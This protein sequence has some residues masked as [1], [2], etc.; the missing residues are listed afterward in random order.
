MITDFLEHMRI[1]VGFQV[2]NKYLRGVFVLKTKL[3]KI[4]LRGYV[5]FPFIF[6]EGNNYI[7]VFFGFK[8]YVLI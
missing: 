7:L 5:S 2:K 6:I 3:L 8:L 4:I 1:I